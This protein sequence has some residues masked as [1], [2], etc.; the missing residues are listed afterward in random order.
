M[1]IEK[2]I[3]RHVEELS[4]MKDS[5]GDIND[6]FKIQDPSSFE[7]YAEFKDNINFL[8]LKIDS[9]YDDFKGKYDSDSDGYLDGNSVNINEDLM[10][11]VDELAEGVLDF[12]KNINELDDLLKQ[13]SNK[14]KFQMNLL[15][16]E[17]AKKD[18][19]IKKLYNRLKSFDSRR[20]SLKI[21]QLGVTSNMVINQDLNLNR[22]NI[23]MKITPTEI[24][25][26]VAWASLG[27][28]QSNSYL[29]GLVFDKPFW[30]IIVR[31]GE[32]MAEYNLTNQP[33]NLN[34]E[35]LI[36]IIYDNG[37]WVFS[38][39]NNVFSFFDDSI[40]IEKLFSFAVSNATLD[41][42]LF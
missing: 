23:Q 5:I 24:H 1:V 31:N 10:V 42:S 40:R 15:K 14:N 33:L 13:V 29:L 7:K 19:H 27:E 39:G 4:I 17:S 12:N 20:I 34:K 41:F 35:S 3:L 16:D 11:E 2:E 38:I 26:S 6:L 18:V 30:G 22:F 28:S 36:E 9:L 32:N 25:H 37:Y 8:S 21:N